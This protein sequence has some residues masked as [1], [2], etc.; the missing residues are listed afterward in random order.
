MSLAEPSRFEVAL[1]FE[2]RR[3]CRGCRTYRR[4]WFVHYGT[5]MRSLVVALVALSVVS[6]VAAEPEPDLTID[7]AT[8]SKVIEGSL[9]ALTKY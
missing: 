9:A 6:L 7:D 4:P 8:R 1:R 2:L 5:A 3:S